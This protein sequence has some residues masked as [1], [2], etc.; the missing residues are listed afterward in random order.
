MMKQ[1]ACLFAAVCLSAATLCAQQPGPLTLEKTITLAGVT[2]KFDHFAVDEV[3]NRLFASA[4]GAGAVLVTDLAS[5]KIVEKL[6]G[7]GKP[8]GLAWIPDTGRLFVTDGA[9][10]ELDV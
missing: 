4:A 10:G 6:E 8:H 5:D 7:L 2:G 9:K 3:G 1:S